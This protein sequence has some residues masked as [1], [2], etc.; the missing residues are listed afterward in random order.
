MSHLSLFKLASHVRICIFKGSRETLWLIVMQRSLTR[1]S[2]ALS[3]PLKGK[4][5]PV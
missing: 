2:A 4:Q 1:G 3:K 5:S